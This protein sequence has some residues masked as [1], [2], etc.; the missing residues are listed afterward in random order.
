MKKKLI[1]GLAAA[2]F[3]FGSM[4]ASATSDSKYPASDFQP[5]VIFADKE[6]A[7]KATTAAEKPAER[8]AFDPKYP[9]TNFEPKVVYADKDLIAQAKPVAKKPAKVEFD[10]RYPAANFV[11]KVIYP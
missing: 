3:T 7:V 5:K 4:T 2:G 10:P 6:L 1:L 8:T 9:A 11:P